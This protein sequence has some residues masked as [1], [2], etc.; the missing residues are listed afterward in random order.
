MGG[1]IYSEIGVGGSIVRLGGWWEIY[2][3][4]GVGGDL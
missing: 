1:E 2:S 3:E 4:I